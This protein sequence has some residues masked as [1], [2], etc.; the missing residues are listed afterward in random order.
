MILE[1]Y[2]LPNMLGT[3]GKILIDGRDYYTVEQPWNN[4]T[5][6]KSCV[7]LGKYELVPYTSDKFGKL[8]MLKNEA[9]GIY[10][11]DNGK[12]R[13]SC[14]AFHRGNYPSDF[15]GCIGIGDSFT[16]VNNKPMVTNTVETCKII[17]EYLYNSSDRELIIIAAEAG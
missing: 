4:N 11:E 13:Y 14:L 2:P 10:T 17:N 12:G 6:F 5:P 16:I 7:P 9:N 8:F 3:F 15:E 1:R